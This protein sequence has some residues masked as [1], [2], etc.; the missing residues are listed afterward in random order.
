MGGQFFIYDAYPYSFK[1]YLTAQQVELREHW[2]YDAIQRSE[3][4]SE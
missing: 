3:A 4:T 1:E 2:E